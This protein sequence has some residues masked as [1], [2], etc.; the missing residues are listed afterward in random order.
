MGNL[1]LRR[2]HLTVLRYALMSAFA[3]QAV[4]HQQ[5]HHLPSCPARSCDGQLSTEETC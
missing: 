3:S 1:M 5:A 4:S 2:K